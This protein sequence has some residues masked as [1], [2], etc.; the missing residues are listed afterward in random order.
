M[1]LSAWMERGLEESENRETREARGSWRGTTLHQ[2]GGR[3][4][5]A[6]FES[7]TMEKGNER[8]Q[9]V[10]GRRCVGDG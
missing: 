1:K 5:A 2:E 4:M 8:R 6:T 9:K 3:Q 10:R 7:E